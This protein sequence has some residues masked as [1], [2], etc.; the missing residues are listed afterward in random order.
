MEPEL[1]GYLFGFIVAAIAVG[2]GVFAL[3]REKEI[4]DGDGN[5]TEIEINNIGKFKSNYPSVAAIAI[6]AALAYFSSTGAKE[7]VPSI[8]LDAR[9]SMKGAVDGKPVFVAAVPQR[10]LTSS[11]TINPD[12]VSKVSLLVDAPT[13]YT[14]IAY[15]VRGVRSTGETVY[16]VAHGPARALS[17][18]SSL[19]FEGTLYVDAQGE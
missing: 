14:V 12:Q 2:G 1:F 9:L 11:N 19:A 16:S 5:V 7:F 10:F 6:G 17:E 4:V 15:T 18:D 13:N 3:F 8:P